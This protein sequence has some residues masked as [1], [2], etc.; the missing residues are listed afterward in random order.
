MPQRSMKIAVF[1]SFAEEN[2]AEHRRL[3]KMTPEQRC[4]EFAILQE[5][6]WGKKWTSEPIVKIATFEKVSWHNGTDHV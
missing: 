4:Q 1:A 5:R 6:Q 2:E 3:A